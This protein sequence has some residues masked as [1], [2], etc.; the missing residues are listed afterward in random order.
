MTMPAFVRIGYEMR[1]ALRGD[2][3][4]TPKKCINSNCWKINRRL[5][6]FLNTAVLIEKAPLYLVTAKEV[7]NCFFFKGL[8]SAISRKFALENRPEK[9]LMLDENV[10]EKCII[11][12]GI[13]WNSCFFVL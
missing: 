7:D 3:Y 1:S 10:P 6:S 12:L 13:R 11:Y 8:G 5:S 2:G 9:I 4:E